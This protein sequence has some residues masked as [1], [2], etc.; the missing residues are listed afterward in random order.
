MKLLTNYEVYKVVTNLIERM[1]EYDDA[2]LNKEADRCE[3]RI[4]DAINYDTRPNADIED[5]QQVHD[6]L[7]ETFIKAR[8]AL[9]G[10]HLRNK[11]YAVI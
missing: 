5:H 10:Y 9:A 11:T 1:R 4:E 6:D 3:E 7:I 2:E 8:S